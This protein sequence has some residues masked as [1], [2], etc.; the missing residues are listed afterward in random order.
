MYLVSSVRSFGS[1]VLTLISIHDENG[2]RSDSSSPQPVSPVKY[3]SLADETD[4]RNFFPIT[5]R[6]IAGGVRVAVAKDDEKDRNLS[7]I[8]GSSKPKPPPLKV[9]TRQRSNSIP[10]TTSNTLIHVEHVS[11]FD[12]EK[13]DSTQFRSFQL[14]SAESPGVL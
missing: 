5:W 2:N 11:D 12:H 9:P 14:F 3:P 6:V 7:N 13:V 8:G 4:K 10:S 1:F